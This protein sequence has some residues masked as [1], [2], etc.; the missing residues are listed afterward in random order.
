MHPRNSV[1]FIFAVI[2]SVFVSGHSAVADSITL[3]SCADTTLLEVVPDNN[4]GGMPFF[5]CGTTQNGTRNRGLVKFDIAGNLPLNCKI[6]W[7]YLVLNVTHHSS[8]GLDIPYFELHR[9]LRDWGEGTNTFDPNGSVGQGAPATLGEATWNDRFAL[10]SNHWASPGGAA[11]IDYVT[12]ITAS[13]IIFTE[14]QS[15]YYFSNNISDA[16]LLVA[17]VQ[18]WLDR[19]ATNFGW[20]ILCNDESVDFTARRIASR[21]GDPFLAPQLYIEYL[22]PPKI[23]NVVQTNQQ[24]NLYF[25]ARAGTNYSVEFR[26][27]LAPSNTWFTLTNFSPFPAPTNLIISDII[28]GTRRFYR[29]RM[30]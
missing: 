3:T 18:T 4:D 11:G 7:A 29:L 9:L 27:D 22:P 12:N 25:T 13:Q 20:M 8:A 17:D 24:L 23:D 14:N 5:N 16:P 26:I 21:E 6:T 15:P 10:T 19:P 1:G 2:A 30:Y 28:T